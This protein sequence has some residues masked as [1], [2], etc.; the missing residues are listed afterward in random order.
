[1][2]DAETRDPN[3]PHDRAH[4][5]R[6]RERVLSGFADDDDVA[7]IVEP[8]AEAL[9]G[10]VF[11]VTDLRRIGSPLVHVEPGFERL[12]GYAPSV[13]VGRDLGFLLHNDTDQDAVREAREAV[14]EGG[15]RRSRCATTVPTVPCSGASSATTPFATLAAASATW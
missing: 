14:R 5:A 8:L 10:E 13:A 3:H 4:L 1:M 12:T 6:L 7:A 2:A 11:V 9:A 15:R